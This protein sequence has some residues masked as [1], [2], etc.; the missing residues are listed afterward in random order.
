MIIMLTILT[1]IGG[2]IYLII[3]LV[4]R[5]KQEKR[6][7]KRVLAFTALY[8]VA[9]FL[10]VPFVA[11]I[12]GREK[13]K[14][15]EHLQSHFFFYT[16]ANRNYVKPEMNAVLTD[17]ANL[18][19]E[20]HPDIKVVYYDACF[21]F[22]DRFPLLPHLSHKDG[23]KVDLAL[24][25]KKDGN[26]TNKKKSVSGYGAYEEPTSQEVDQNEFCKSRGYFQYD[27]PKYFTLGTVNENM[28]LSESVT[29]DLINIISARSE[30]GKIFIE[31]YLKQ[32]EIK[33]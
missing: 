31:P 25:Y 22:F 15:T 9:T 12:F 6:R 5:K 2:I 3:L 11:P 27:F 20:R 24:I 13:I 18:F 8:L 17:V 32:R 28:E 7:L 14:N 16:L 21:P 29:A 4:F 23:K 19:A 26:P 33:Q 1:Q 10:I 30:I